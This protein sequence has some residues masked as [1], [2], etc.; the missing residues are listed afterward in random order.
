M[1]WYDRTHSTIRIVWHVC[2]VCQ[3]FSTASS[4]SRGAHRTR[5][6]D[7][8]ERVDEEHAREY[9]LLFPGLKWLGTLHTS[10][11]IVDNSE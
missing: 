11:R 6:G 8:L 2:D 3:P 10:K 4:D 9:V 5:F 1:C 7:A